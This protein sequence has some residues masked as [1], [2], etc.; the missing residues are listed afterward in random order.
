MYCNICICIT[1]SDPIP[2]CGVDDDAQTCPS[3]VPITPSGCYQQ[4]VYDACCQ[5]CTNY[6]YERK[7][8][9]KI[10]YVQPGRGVKTGEMAQSVSSNA[11][12]YQKRLS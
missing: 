7:A 6:Y 9:G 10:L 5:S 8:A 11:I 12:H 2:S 4:S 1:C 3:Y